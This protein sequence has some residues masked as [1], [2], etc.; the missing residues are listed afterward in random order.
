MKPSRI[1]CAF[2]LVTFLG[3]LAASALNRGVWFS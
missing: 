3:S 1:E 2:F